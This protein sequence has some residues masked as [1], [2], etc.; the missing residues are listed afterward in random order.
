MLSDK[1]L[2]LIWRI[3]YTFAAFLGIAFLVL[4]LDEDRYVFDFIGR[5]SLL[6]FLF[7]TTRLVEWK[8]L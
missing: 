8:E 4:W 6:Y 2:A 7:K 1:A 3:S 5:I